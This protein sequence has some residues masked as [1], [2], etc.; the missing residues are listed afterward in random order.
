MTTT[1]ESGR[2]RRRA[3]VALI[4]LYVV[5]S[6]G[7]LALYF[8]HHRTRLETVLRVY[9]EPE[10][11][12]DQASPLLITV[13][14]H[15][16]GRTA[17]PQEL[18]VRWGG[19]ELELESGPAGP[20]GRLP[21][22][23]SAR[24]LSVHAADGTPGGRQVDVE[25]RPRM[26]AD[27]LAEP[28]AL[29]GEGSPRRAELGDGSD[30]PRAWVREPEDACPWRLTV[31]AN[32]GVVARGLPNDLYLR[33]TDGAGAPRAD[34]TITLRPRDEPDPRPPRSLRTDGLG[35]AAWSGA[36][37]A[38]PESWM[39]AF[40]CES[41]PGSPIVERRLSIVPSWDGVVLR[42]APVAVSGQP[43]TASITHQRGWGDWF[44]DVHCDG[45]WIESSIAAVREGTSEFASRVPLPEVERPTWC[46]LTASLRRHAVDPPRA[47]AHVLAVPQ[48][49]PAR[50]LWASVTDRVAPHV[51][52]GVRAQ[53]GPL[54][55]AALERGS[56]ADLRRYGRWLLDRL[57]YVVRPPEVLLDD[58]TGATEAFAARR[59]RVLG[60]LTLA[61]LLDAIIL[62]V[63]VVGVVAPAA[64]AQRMRLQAALE[65][66]ALELDVEGMEELDR[67]VIVG[68]LG[69]LVVVAAVLGL[70]ALLL[71]LR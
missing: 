14:D 1:S 38:A 27:L 53:L 26:P 52:P 56:E 70:V 8:H 36:T 18:R 22:T 30:A 58:V 54:S 62:L 16:T 51:Y 19:T 15:S 57:P 28:S 66:P 23:P 11:L 41:L 68:V 6:A 67:P 42:T 40:A 35:V 32:G 50:E 33:L 13:I 7:A 64:R 46:T 25:V 34:T 20:E 69:V 24:V 43:V 5:Q 10:P 49:T 29:A 45:V 65:D 12:P 71:V 55:R 4:G 9:G 44:F 31:S 61:L 48:G 3:V 60:T 39:A 59:A 63:G 21:G 17:R 47:Q 37:I 2:W